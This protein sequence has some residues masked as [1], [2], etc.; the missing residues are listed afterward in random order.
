MSRCRRRLLPPLYLAYHDSL[1]EPTEV[2]HNDIRGRFNR[3]E[4]K[5]VDAMKHLAEI[6]SLGREAIL[7]QD[8]ALLG[9]LMDDNFN[10]RRGIYNLAAL[11]GEHG[12]GRPPM[13]RQREFRGFRRRDHRHLPGRGDVR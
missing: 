5:V 1:S 11:A 2:F 4:P 6:T 13:R 3:G 8:Y 9:Q 12:R 7:Q 10:V